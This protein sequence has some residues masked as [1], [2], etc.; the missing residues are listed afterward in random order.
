MRTT[1]QMFASTLTILATITSPQAPQSDPP[2]V[3]PITQQ[4][5]NPLAKK[6]RNQKTRLQYKKKRSLRVTVQ[7]QEVDH[8]Q[9][10]NSLDAWNKPG[11]HVILQSVRWYTVVQSDWITIITEIKIRYKVTRIRRLDIGW[12]RAYGKHTRSWPEISVSSRCTH[13]ACLL[14]FFLS[15]I[16]SLISHLR[17]EYQKRYTKLSVWFSRH[18]T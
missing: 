10:V 8:N 1:E 17:R 15:L 18:P 16:K 9:E 4:S 6:T 7:I 12:V 2:P 14:T 5:S 13:V 3:Q 11:K